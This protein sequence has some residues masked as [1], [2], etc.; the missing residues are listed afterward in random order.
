MNTALFSR[1]PSFYGMWCLFFLLNSALAYTQ[2]RSDYSVY[3]QE[4]LDL[5]ELLSQGKYAVALDKYERLVESYPFVFLREHKVAAQLAL[6]INKEEK[7]IAY[8]RR[9]IKAGWKWR[10]IRKNEL[11]SRLKGTEAWKKNKAE[12]AN[13]RKE[14][15]GRFPQELRAQ[16]RKMFKKDQRK[17][18]RALFTFGPNGQDRYA[19]R[20]FAPHSEQQIGKLKKILS[21]Y[22]YPGERLV[23]NSYWMS[24]ILSHHNSIS[25]EYN[26]RDTLYA[27]VRPALEIALRKGELSPFSFALIEDWYLASSKDR[28]GDTYG[29]LQQPTAAQLETTNKRR[30]NIYLRSVELRNQLVEVEKRTGIDL[31]LPGNPWVDGKIEIGE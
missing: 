3:H 15:V 14:F 23:G 29:F 13:L 6:F 16:V 28:D 22:G 24:T 11:L 17:A 21:K 20:H 30:Q 2:S 8:M 10:A 12:Y 1:R 18:F 25:T 26:R 9:G 19:E 7:A 4:V 27:S 31:F 5:E